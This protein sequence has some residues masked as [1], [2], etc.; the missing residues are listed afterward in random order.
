MPHF[1]S[2][3]PHSYSSY[4]YNF[5]PSGPKDPA[6][7]KKKSVTFSLPPTAP[8]RRPLHSLAYTSTDPLLASSYPSSL[9]SV[10][11][12]IRGRHESNAPLYSNLRISERPAIVGAALGRD[13]PKKSVIRWTYVD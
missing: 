8:K 12:R 6:T 4:Q 11:R 5:V 1:P 10:S 3:I 2:Y 9:V 7:H 13:A